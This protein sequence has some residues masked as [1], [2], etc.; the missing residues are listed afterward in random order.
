MVKER[1][2]PNLR[3]LTAE[4]EFSTSWDL[5]VAAP[6]DALIVRFLGGQQVVHDTGEVMGGGSNGLGLAE[7]SS[8][9]SEE[10]A[11]TGT[12]SQVASDQSG[13]SPRCLC[14]YDRDKREASVA[15]PSSN[16]RRKLVLLTLS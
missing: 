1:P 11:E 16:H 15:K 4:R 9:A 7:L 13:F 2:K 5:L 3:S 14:L 8:D 6:K 12:G 10:L